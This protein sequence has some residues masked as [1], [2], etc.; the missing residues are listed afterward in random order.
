MS[1]D[2]LVFSGFAVKRPK[3]K[4]ARSKAIKFT[5]ATPLLESTE[6]KGDLLIRDLWQNGTDSLHD[7]RIVNIDAN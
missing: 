4:T 5:D 3:A 7:M 2:L 6:Q 1:N